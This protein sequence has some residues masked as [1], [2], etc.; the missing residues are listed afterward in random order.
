MS[1]SVGINI[2]PISKPSTEASSSFITPH[3]PI[4]SLKPEDLNDP[5]SLPP[6]NEDTTVINF[7]PRRNSLPSSPLVDIPLRTSPRLPSPAPTTASSP[8]PLTRFLNF[9]NS[10]RLNNLPPPHRTLFTNVPTQPH[11]PP[12]LINYPTVDP[13]HPPETVYPIHLENTNPVPPVIVDINPPNIEPIRT[14][15]PEAPLV[16]QPDPFSKCP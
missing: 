4:P 13:I 15:T 8:N 1:Q 11:H 6:Y 5:L 10:A 12:P 2:S 3:H 16:N 14:P 9:I 7:S